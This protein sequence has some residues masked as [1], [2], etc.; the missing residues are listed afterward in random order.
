MKKILLGIG[1]GITL[2]GLSVWV[3]PQNLLSALILDARPENVILNTNAGTIKIKLFYDEAPEIADNFYKLARSGKYDSTIFHRVI[4]GFVIQGGDYEN[5]NGTG[6]EAFKGGFLEDEISNSLS[7]VRG[8]VSMANKGP[9]T[10]GS[11]FFIVHEDAPFLDGKHSIFGQVIS[12]MSVIDKISRMP[13]D[14]NDKPLEAVVIRSVSF[15]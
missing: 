4:K 2:V 13:T 14:A 6:G 7:H 1:I 11:Q 8:A 3:Q 15:E 5:A 9:D 12:N 10:N